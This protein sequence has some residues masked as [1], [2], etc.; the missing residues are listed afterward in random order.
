MFKL[1]SNTNQPSKVIQTQTISNNEKQIPQYL[2][3]VHTLCISMTFYLCSI[4]QQNNC[5][6]GKGTKTKN[7]PEM[8][9]LTPPPGGSTPCSGQCPTSE[10]HSIFIP[11]P[12]IKQLFSKFKRSIK[13]IHQ[14][15]NCDT[16]TN[17]EY[18]NQQGSKYT[19]QHTL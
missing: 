15:N 18:P 13:T 1:Y 6:Y 17:Y 9:T 14:Q 19:N 11:F 2:K 16:Q 8:L 3:I 12:K 4:H 10:M 5:K 7:I